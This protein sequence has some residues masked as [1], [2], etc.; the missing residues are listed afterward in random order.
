MSTVFFSKIPIK[1]KEKD[2]KSIAEIY[3]VVCKISIPI[4][5][6]TRQSKGFAFI[7]FDTLA[8]AQDFIH[9]LHDI[10]Y[11]G[12][13]LIAELADHRKSKGEKVKQKK[14]DPLSKKPNK[15]LPSWKRKE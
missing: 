7:E 1:W 13:T 6:K 12:R 5:Y 15:K 4:D 3:G 2:I 11:E 10:S 8:E 14:Q 9:A